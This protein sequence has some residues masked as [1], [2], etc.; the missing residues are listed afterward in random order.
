MINALIVSRLISLFPPN[1]NFSRPS[2][3]EY[4][5]WIGRRTNRLGTRILK[6]ILYAQTIAA[7]CSGVIGFWVLFGFLDEHC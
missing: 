6:T 5:G 1:E 4:Q 3:L 7:L 2:I